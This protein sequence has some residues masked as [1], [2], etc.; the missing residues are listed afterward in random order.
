VKYKFIVIIFYTLSTDHVI[1]KQTSNNIWSVLFIINNHD[2]FS[3]QIQDVIKLTTANI[4]LIKNFEQIDEKINSWINN[5]KYLAIVIWDHKEKKEINRHFAEN[6]SQKIN[7]IN[8]KIDILCLDFCYSAT[9]EIIENISH[10]ADFVIANQDRQF[11]DG[12]CYDYIFETILNQQNQEQSCK[13]LAQEIVWHTCNKYLGTD[14]FNLI[15]MVAIDCQKINLLTPF[16][17]QLEKLKINSCDIFNL[18]EKQFYC[19]CFKNFLT[20]NII[21]AQAKTGKYQSFSGISI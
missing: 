7:K 10:Q 6:L 17:N 1:D 2:L 19:S 5:Y 20:N 21:I 8:K 16:M 11:M 9:I 18:I 3:N 14:Q 12:F 13:K 15:N 4:K